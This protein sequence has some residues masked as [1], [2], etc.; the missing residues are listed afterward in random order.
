M[1][2]LQAKRLWILLLALHG[3][4]SFGL[5]SPNSTG[6][7]IVQAYADA[8]TVTAMLPGMLSSPVPTVT[9]K[10][11]RNIQDV[12]KNVRMAIDNYWDIAGLSNCAKVAEAVVPSTTT[13]APTL[14][15]AAAIACAGPN[16][17]QLLTALNASILQLET[18]LI[19][20]QGGK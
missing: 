15:P 6:Q 5:P 18:F 9:S 1:K 8:L 16:G 7:K 19:A 4:A 2:M 3:C 14:P 13:P 10:Q 20:H 11:A 12:S 17:L